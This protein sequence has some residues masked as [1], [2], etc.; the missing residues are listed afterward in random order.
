MEKWSVCGNYLLFLRKGSDILKN[1]TKQKKIG[2]FLFM[3]VSM[4]LCA[5]VF[6][7]VQTHYVCVHIRCLR[8]SFS[9]LHLEDVSHVNSTSLSSHLTQDRW[10]LHFQCQDHMW[11]TIPVQHS[12]R[13]LGSK[14]FKKLNYFQHATFVKSNLFENNL[15]FSSTEMHAQ[16]ASFPITKLFIRVFPTGW[17]KIVT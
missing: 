4:N 5:C 8:S 13:C 6:S 12:D 17:A 16:Q 14:Y 1:D 11:L 15:T 7:C 2:N 10:A 9:T 3:Y